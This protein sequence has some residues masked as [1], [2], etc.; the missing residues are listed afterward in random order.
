MALSQP[1]ALSQRGHIIFEKHCC[2]QNRATTK[3]NKCKKYCFK[4]ADL[5]VFLLLRKA[6]C[7]NFRAVKV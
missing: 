6:K 1:L 4:K 3:E 5:N 7:T 2:F